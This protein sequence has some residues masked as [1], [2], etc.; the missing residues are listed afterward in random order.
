MAN[1]LVSPFQ[2]II[3]S[4]IDSI[5]DVVLTLPMCAWLKHL[6][7]NIRISFL[8]SGYTQDVLA[9]CP[10][11][12]QPLNWTIIAPQAVE[13]QIQFFNDL[14]ADAFV[15]VFPN[16]ELARLV[17]R[18]NIRTAI[19]TRNRF[20]HWWTCSHLVA[21]SR[22]HSPLHE[23]ELNL[24]LLTKWLPQPLPD[25]Q[26]LAQHYT[27]SPQVPNPAATLTQLD[28]NKRL[29]ILHPKS[30]GSAREWPASHWIELIQLLHQQYGNRIQ[31]AV[32]GT[33]SEGEWVKQQLAPV[34]SIFSDLTGQLSLAQLIA[35]IAQSE[36]LIACSTGPLHI[37]AAL[38]RKAIGLYVPLRP[39]DP[40]RW[41]P[42]GK[43]AQ[44][45]CL[46]PPCNACRKQPQSCHCI[47]GISPEMVMQAMRIDS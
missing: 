25:R 16:P 29:W 17:R 32:S 35:L 36:G 31:I 7:P 3:I 19:G 21:L 44:A 24:R 30:K 18:T 9:A 43:Q 37:A 27:L 46:P 12:D 47:T 28:S 20:Y 45:L 34:A 33:A 40:G 1:N 11:I 2:H 15:H 6:Y 22:R 39:L 8:A 10:A 26:I 23:A 13:A 5:G 14:Q 38:G 41:A 4:R 42:L